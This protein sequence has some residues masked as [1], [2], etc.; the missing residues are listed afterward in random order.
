MGKKEEFLEMVEAVLIN[1]LKSQGFEGSRIEL[2]QKLTSKL[3]V[4]S[5]TPKMLNITYAAIKHWEKKGFLLFPANKDV[6]EWR[7]FSVLEYFWIMVLKKV[8]KIGGSLDK[9]VPKIK[10]AYQHHTNPNEIIK[11]VLPTAEVNTETNNSHLVGFITHILFAYLQKGKT[12]L[13]LFE[14]SCQ[15]VAENG[16][17]KTNAINVSHEL[18]YKTGISICIS[19]IIFE[20]IETHK[21][22]LAVTH[23]H[24]ENE[25]EIIQHLRNNNL[26]EV[27]I[28]LKDGKPIF[29]ELT[30]TFELHKQN[31]NKRLLQFLNSP[32]QEIKAVTSCGQTIYFER[33][34]K[35][36]LN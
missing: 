26:K 10:F 14:D 3:L 5:V 11:I 7:K 1:N 19:D 35:Q 8:V 22:R 2:M 20:D 34:T 32:Y 29:I 36:K 4:P 13:H 18:M 21:N 31:A 23:L 12:T 33:K 16:D 24:S 28:K 17:K 6:D 30:E 15:F 25:A 27:T 9:I